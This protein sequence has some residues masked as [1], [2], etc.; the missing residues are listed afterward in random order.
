M[1]HESRDFDHPN[2]GRDPYTAP[3]AIDPLDEVQ[4]V[5]TFAGLLKASIVFAMVAP[6]AAS[7][8]M[9]VGGVLL[10]ICLEVALVVFGSLLQFWFA[11]WNSQLFYTVV[12]SVAI[13]VSVIFGVVVGLLSAR[14]TLPCQVRSVS[15]GEENGLDVYG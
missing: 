6:I 5:Y 12:S 8:V 4:L 1:N 13:G 10:F 11:D 14:D 7:V 2:S 3:R 15:A 9:L